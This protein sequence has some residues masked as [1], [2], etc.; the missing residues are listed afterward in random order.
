MMAG[1]LF[2]QRFADCMDTAIKNAQSLE[3]NQGILNPLENLDQAIE[4]LRCYL[5]D[6]SGTNDIPNA[7]NTIADK[8]LGLFSVDD[9]V[10]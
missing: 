1:A 3:C 7:T 4:V 8:S 2:P 10:E 6:N 5:E 9:E